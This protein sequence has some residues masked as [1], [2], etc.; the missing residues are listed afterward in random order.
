MGVI[1]DY[2]E[3]LGDSQRAEL[4]RI[5]RIVLDRAPDAEEGRGYG[6][7]AFRYKRKPLLGFAALKDHLSLFPFSPHVV[8]AVKGRLAGYDL[9]KGT[10]R[11]T[12]AKPIPEDVIWEILDEPRQRERHRGAAESALGDRRDER[13]ASVAAVGE[14]L[15]GP[16]AVV[17]QLSS[18]LRSGLGIGMVVIGSA[19]SP[20][21]GAQRDVGNARQDGDSFPF[22]EGGLCPRH[23]GWSWRPHLRSRRPVAP[24]ECPGQC[25]GCQAQTMSV[26]YVTT[27]P[28][29]ARS[30]KRDPLWPAAAE[31]PVGRADRQHENDNP[32]FA[33][34][35]LQIAG[36]SRQAT[37]QS[38]GIN[39]QGPAQTLPRLVA[40]LAT[41]QASWDGR[42]VVFG[43]L[44]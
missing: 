23:W 6:M 10:I 9:S 26:G 22:D 16:T 18:L 42:K 32:D 35:W 33:L 13:R 14:L 34:C 15:A 28:V 29:E 39:G 8:A 7:P 11:F 4:E 40:C 2:L 20:A 43:Q 36:H 37:G 27:S 21:A 17:E 19:P 44:G 3:G 31:I 24:V 1:D 30:G 38:P 41:G 12:E 25:P 5:R